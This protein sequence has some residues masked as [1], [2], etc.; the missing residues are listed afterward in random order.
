MLPG[1]VASVLLWGWAAIIPAPLG[2]PG[3]ED[4]VSESTGLPS[5]WVVSV[6]SC[7]WDY[8]RLMQGIHQGSGRLGATCWPPQ[9]RGE[10]PEQAA[11]S[12]K[13][14]RVTSLQN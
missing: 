8:G 13:T 7:G 9:Q 14:I 5:A 2:R 3:E 12:G 6:S 11:G 1:Q 4:K 10:R